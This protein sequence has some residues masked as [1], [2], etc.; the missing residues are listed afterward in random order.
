MHT[1]ETFVPELSASEGEV[2]IGKLKRY[3]SPGVVQIPS[4]LIQAGGK[5][6]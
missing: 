2:P 6:L 3:K 5:T 4:K 1:A